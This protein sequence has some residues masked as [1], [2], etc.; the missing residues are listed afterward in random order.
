MLATTTLA[1]EHVT[2]IK[3]LGNVPEDEIKKYMTK[4][5]PNAV[6]MSASS[7][8][9]HFFWTSVP[10]DPQAAFAKP[11]ICSIVNSN[12]VEPSFSIYNLILVL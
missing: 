6:Q 4:F 3:E 2:A 5:D 1:L 11:L 8:D 7:V 9:P 10:N 12:H